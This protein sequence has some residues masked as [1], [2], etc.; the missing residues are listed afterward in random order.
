[1]NTTALCRKIAAEG[2]VLL[3]NDNDVLP[4]AKG[5]RLAVFGRA[6][7]FY[8]KS[9]TGSGGLV[10]IDKEPCIIESLKENDDLVLDTAL[11]AQY[12]AWVEE[13]PFQDGE[14]KWASEPWFQEEMPVDDATAA[15]A[16]SRNDA[17][18][19]VL[20]R[21]AGEDHDNA[22]EE[23][24]YR[25]TA[26]EERL[27]ATVTRH[28]DK[29]IVALNV[30]NMIDTAFA[31]TYPISSL[32]YIWQGG[33][34]GANAF[35]D[36]L[37]G[38]SA[39]CGKL[40]DT[41]AWRISDH[42]SHA[43][44]GS[45]E[46]NIYAEDV[47]VGYRYFE[48]FRKDAVQYPFGF[49]LTYTTFET[50]YTAAEENGIITVTATVTNSGK[51]EGREVVQVY[52]DAPCG[53]L[54]TPARQLVA[55]AK[56]PM[57]APGE[58]ATLAI[59]FA[60]RDMASYDDSGVT[61]HRSCYV[62]ESGDYTVYVGTDVRAAQAVLCH[63]VAQTTV[64]ETLE[65]AMAP[66][67][68]FD[69]LVA[70]ADNGERIMSY[71]AVTPA[72]Y[73]V[74][75]RIAARRPEAV[76]FTGD[77]GIKLKDVYDK[78][79]SLD[80]FI[81]Q[82]SD[83]D[84]AALVC[85]E[86]M[87][88]PKATPGTGG[89]LGGQTESLSNFGIPVCAVTDGP[90]GIRRDSGEK[91]SSIPNGTLLACTWDVEL[92]EELYTRIGEELKQH[93]VDALLGPG[94]NLH[95]HPLCGRNFEYFSEDPR[96]TGLLAAAVTRGIAKSGA[97]STI[98]HFCANNQETNRYGCESVVSERALRELYLKPFEIAV[99]QGENVL[100][101]TA[102]N[103]VN[104]YWTASHYDLTCTILRGE[105][106]FDNF[107]MTDW[108][109]KCNLSCHS[110]GSGGYVQAMVRAE[111]DVF[112]VCED[113]A[114]KGEAVLDG[115]RDGYI[116]R[117]ELQRC[118][119]NI[120]DWIL[121]TNTFVDYLERDCTPLYPVTRDDSAMTVVAAVQSP[122]VETVYPA[123]LKAGAAS[124]T[125][126]LKSNTDVLAQTAV[127][128]AVGGIAVTASVCGTNGEYIT[129]KRFVDIP[130]D[131]KGEITLAHPDVIEVASIHIKQA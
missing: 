61:G 83:S 54:G 131:A 117:G 48:T 35:A 87:N 49:G 73:A 52:Y 2:A 50:A 104:G 75:E 68:A 38:K 105:W 19:I 30:G 27:L 72:T 6:Q 121:R 109:A 13:H 7:T 93:Q 122:A 120:C 103:P 102:Y 127:T 45:R 59:P 125:L 118:A 42:P 20:A 123:A 86:G 106:G 84:L 114:M 91:A 36:L 23:G 40:S 9:G 15:A 119:R 99:K 44:F 43:N 63:T 79:A 18:V 71:R 4:L 11:I 78:N 47:Y 130:A 10:H 70:A 37:S 62:L 67:E 12:A 28:V 46:K 96:L 21:T 65:E 17:A 80:A 39:P 128:V 69:R 82:L 115:L 34:E 53:M 26:E 101:M 3:K 56:T 90:S 94:I 55:F 66:V 124:V 81:A 16:A 33:M 116:T 41:A 107:V 58:S 76:A 111:N 31:A 32:L 85:G 110:E 112:M 100:I 64:V 8:Y 108:W 60:V 22:D 57:I 95:R 126:R 74:E 24:S 98:K 29:V 5:T 25:L 51:R 113:A 89:A 1:M 77:K 92:V 14:G 88:S 97:F 129:V